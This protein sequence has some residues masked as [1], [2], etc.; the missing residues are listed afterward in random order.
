MVSPLETRSVDRS[1]F[2]PSARND[3]RVQG[4][5]M[6]SLRLVT[7]V[8]KEIGDEGFTAVLRCQIHPRMCHAPAHAPVFTFAITLMY[9]MSAEGLGIC[10]IRW[11]SAKV[12]RAQVH[13]SLQT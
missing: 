9:N 1:N 6:H 2:K 12:R 4:G 7:I 13:L 8:A 11:S 5:Y 10:C 3:K